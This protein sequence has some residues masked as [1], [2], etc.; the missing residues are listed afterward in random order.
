MAFQK[1]AEIDT[2]KVSLSTGSI[3]YITHYFT[4]FT[5]F[6]DPFY[7]IYFYIISFFLRN[8]N[9]CIFINTFKCIFTN[10]L[11]L[12]RFH[13]NSFQVFTSWKSIW[14]NRLNIFSYC[15]FLF[16]RLFLK[17]SFATEVTLNFTPLILIVSGIDIVLLI[18]VVFIN[19]TVPFVIVELVTWYVLFVL[20]R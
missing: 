17:A 18:I 7:W 4:N 19:L 13:N 20:D 8:F 1:H 14:T 9:F 16:F 3:I 11:Y 6:F 12:F 15:N 10:R 2:E 5:D